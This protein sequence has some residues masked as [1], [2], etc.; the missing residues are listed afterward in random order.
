MS[1]YY[2]DQPDA[3]DDLEVSQPYLEGNTNAA[4]D[5]FSVDHAAFSDTSGNR[6]LHKKVT[7]YAYQSDPS[8]AYPTGEIYTKSNGS[9]PNRIPNLYYAYKPETNSQIIV[10][11][12]GNN[13][14]ETGTTSPIG[15]TY[16]LFQTP[17]GVKIF[18]G[19]TNS[20]AGTR[21]LTI[22]GTNSF[23]NIIYSSNCTPRFSSTAVS[24]SPTPSSKNFT[25]QID[26]GP[27]TIWWM[28]WT[29]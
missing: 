11:L 10:P 18:C 14:I 5:A 6:G 15:G 26:S 7:L 3:N 21:T 2:R 24:I 27:D 1:T 4:D 22:S 19:L 25:I 8:L 20:F 16:N 13:I 29:N 17:W 28:I 9:A 12:A 23:G